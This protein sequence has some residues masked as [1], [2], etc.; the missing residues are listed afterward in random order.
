MF[1]LAGEWLGEPNCAAAELTVAVPRF[2]S[3]LAEPQAWTPGAAWPLMVEA[4]GPTDSLGLV[5]TEW[6]DGRNAITRTGWSSSAATVL[7]IVDA[8]ERLS[9]AA[10]AFLTEASR[11]ASAASG[12]R[13]VVLADVDRAAHWHVPGRYLATGWC[14]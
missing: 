12:I 1:D 4:T 13:V 3:G 14:R 8:A 11:L 6:R 2:D 9:K 10:D 5:G 7:A